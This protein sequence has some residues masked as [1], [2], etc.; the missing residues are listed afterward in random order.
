MAVVLAE[1]GLLAAHTLGIK[2]LMIEF[3]L[4]VS[5]Y[6]CAVEVVLFGCAVL[7]GYGQQPALCFVGVTGN[8]SGTQCQHAARSCSKKKFFHCL[9]HFIG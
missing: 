9:N 7:Q 2:G 3:Q 6:A 8:K 5:L 4:G 1:E